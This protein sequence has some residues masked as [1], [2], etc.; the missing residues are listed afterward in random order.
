MGD[1]LNFPKQPAN[2]SK[3]SI[4][5]FI[6]KMSLKVGL[7]KAETL[8]VYEHYQQLH[9]A[10]TDKFQMPLRL[11]ANLSL[12]QE[13]ISAIEEALKEHITDLHAYSV[14]VTVGL[15]IREQI[16]LR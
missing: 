3:D 12:T 8:S 1:I 16:N 6:D 10:L 5:Q 9:D 11:S 7:S 4:R 2:K 14:S 13:Q 15:L